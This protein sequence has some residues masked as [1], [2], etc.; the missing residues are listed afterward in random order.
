MAKRSRKVKLGEKKKTKTPQ[1]QNHTHT[2]QSLD[3]YHT[4]TKDR[5]PRT[6]YRQMKKDQYRC[7]VLTLRSSPY[8]TLHCYVL[9]DMKGSTFP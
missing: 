3:P 2:M 6:K 7:D 8:V 4:V 9:R 5:L 1:N